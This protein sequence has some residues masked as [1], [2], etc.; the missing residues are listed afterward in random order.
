M[1][2]ASER[3]THTVEPEME[4]ALAS[5]ARRTALWQLGVM[6]PGRRVPGGTQ[7]ALP[8]GLPAPPELAPLSDWEQML[9]DYGATGLTTAAHP[10]ALLRP[11]LAADVVS[12]RDLRRLDHRSRVRIG[13]L[14]VARQRPGTAS[15]IVFVLLEDEFGTVNLVIPPGVY[16]RNRLVVRTEPLMLVGGTLERLAAAGGAINVLVDT[17]GSID[18]P[19]RIIA[20][21]KDF[22]L[23]DEGVRRGL[24]EQR[25]GAAAGLRVVGEDGEE[26]EPAAVARRGVPT[27]VAA[28]AAAGMG[29]LEGGEA[30]DFRAVAPPVMSFAQGRRR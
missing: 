13:G 4:H 30:E 28:A 5:H 11:R 14:V 9:A 17:V 2:H 23:L 24:E 8:L 22:S 19:D 10:L 16:E 29:G 21:I 6:T 20:E 27:E 25:Q 3:G 18:A 26:R 7:L 12:S 1:G 15:G